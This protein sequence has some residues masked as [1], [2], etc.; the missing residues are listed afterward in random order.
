MPA[1]PTQL[2]QIKGMRCA[3]CAAH[4]QHAVSQLNSVQQAT[5]NFATATLSI[6]WQREAQVE[7]VLDTIQHI[8]YQASAIQSITQQQAQYQAD[9][10]QQQQ[11]LQ[12]TLVKMLSL[13]LL[14]LSISMGDMLGLPLPN[15]LKAAHPV[16][17]I[18]V[19]LVLTLPVMWWGRHYYQ[20]G[21]KRLFQGLPN[22]DALIALSTAIAFLQG[23]ITWLQTLFFTRSTT[24]HQHPAVY[25]ESVAVIL[26]FVTL[27]HFL[28]FIAKNK[29]TSALFS[30]M[31]LA[32]TTAH[33]LTLS[34]Q[35]ERIDPRLLA[36]G[37]TIL[38][39]A[40]EQVPIDAKI[41]KGIS[42]LDESMLSGESLPVTKQAGDLIYAAS[43]NLEANLIAEV[44][45]IG[46]ETLFT[47]I[48]DLVQNAQNN[49]APLA[50]LAD[51]IAHYFVPTVIGLALLSGIVWLLSGATWQH[52]LTI[53]T[54]VLIIACPCALGLATPTAIMVAT[55]QAAKRGIL[56]KNGSA[57]EQLHRINTV[58]LDKTGTLT[59]GKPQ[60]T[61]WQFDP[62]SAHFPLEAWIH[63]VELQSQ[64]PIATAL[65]HHLQQKQAPLIQP[66]A[67][68][69][70]IGQG[71]TAQFG[72]HQLT[73]GNQSLLSQPLPLH[74]EKLV[75]EWQQEAKT[76]L[77][78]TVDTQLVGLIALSDTLR[79]TSAKAIQKL[80]EH[81]IHTIMATGDQANVAQAIAVQAGISTIHSQLLPQDKIALVQ[82]LQENGQHVLMVGDGINDAP[83]LAGADISLAIGEG[84]DIALATADV[85]LMQAN[86]ELIAT[87]IS[88]SDQTQRIIKQNLFWAFAYNIIGIP[89]A[90]GVLTLLGGPLLNP[91]F[92]A[93]AMS[94]SSLSVLLNT[95][96]LRRLGD[97]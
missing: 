39:K 14:L 82:Q 62:A 63:G 56:F 71:V 85:I 95:L 92:A 53:A 55:G 23:V 30:L 2:F 42:Q 89:I 31:A 94:A 10:Q 88:I 78:V 93:L 17:F 11:L 72:A 6:T 80:R 27:G 7:E 91:M 41:I 25:F 60:V 21:F 8:G 79:P 52:A 84:T 50:Q 86:L 76:V 96:R 20:N 33:R 57:L 18:A 40:G 1:N 83:A 48:I 24:A 29:T 34:G 35:I 45:T 46:T 4:V 36:I 59:L 65:V 68:H 73:I 64:H 47:K 54:D 90:M 38:I 44:T 51:R 28:E 13:T 67:L 19:Q 22:M 43:L 75:L 81:Q 3:S 61:N 58:V 97:K 9:L 74:W 69:Q 77:F 32:P 12:T 15:G 66:D 5:L 37:D 49:K 70:H 16:T 87:A 26:T